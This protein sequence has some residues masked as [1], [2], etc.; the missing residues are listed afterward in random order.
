M[1]FFDDQ[2]TFIFFKDAPSVIMKLGVT[3][4]SPAEKKPEMYSPAHN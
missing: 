3:G 2:L 4:Y 1:P